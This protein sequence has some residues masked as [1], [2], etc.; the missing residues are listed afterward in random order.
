MSVASQRGLPAD[1]AGAQQLGAAL[2]LVA[3]G[4]PDHGEEHAGWRR[5]TAPKAVIFEHGDAAE[6]GRVVDPAVEGDQRRRDVDRLGGHAPRRRGRVDAHR[7]RGRAGRHRGQ[8]E[9]PDGQQ[10]PVAA[11]DQPANVQVPA[12]SLVPD[13]P[14]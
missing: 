13:S 7:G 6:V 2:L 12:R 5:S 1:H 3:A 4:V 9:Q 10:D 11:Q 8:D 14:R